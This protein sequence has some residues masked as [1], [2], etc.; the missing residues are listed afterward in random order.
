MP[1]L[2]ID[3]N[4][5][6]TLESIAFARGYEC[7]H[8]SHLGLSGTKDWELKQVVLEGDWTFLT[9]NNV[10]FRGPADAPGSAGEYADVRL[11][12]GLICITSDFPLN[13]LRQQK[14]FE[15]I[16]DELDVRRDLTNMVMEVDVNASGDVAT[17][18]Y[19]LPEETGDATD[20]PSR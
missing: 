10:D 6:P 19:A 4:L 7:A 12:A 17:R 20:Q 11:H 14:V 1:K 2:L 13:R 8:V 15:A 3:E 18:A 5:S 9:A 16:L